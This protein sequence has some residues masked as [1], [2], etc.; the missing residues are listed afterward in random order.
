MNRTSTHPF[1]WSVRRELWE[2]RS[3]YFAPLLA[4]ALALFGFFLSTIGMAERRRAVL[5]LD[6]ALQRARIEAPYD[7]VAMF[8]LVVG[9][10]VGLFYCLEALHG[11]RRDRSILFWKSLPVSDRTVVLAKASVPLVLLPLITFVLVVLTQLIMVLWSTVLLALHG[12]PPA[13]ASQLPLLRG[14]AVLLYGLAAMALWHAPIYGWFL[15]VSAWARR[16][17]FLWVLLPLT[18]GVVE[19]LAFQTRGFWNFLKYRTLGGIDQAFAFQRQALP[20]Q[21]RPVP[22]VDPPDLTPFNFLITP[23]LW[24]G[25]IFA[26]A[27]LFIAIRLR[28]SHGPL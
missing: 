28:R 15:L 7:S 17:T 2:N 3:L 11:E 20:P 26:A 25:L 22:T 18:L 1:Y 21:Q 27:C 6:P 13:T 10:L 14:W 24:L 9:I 16:A 19:Q 12:L 23:G 8:L 4:S 5:L